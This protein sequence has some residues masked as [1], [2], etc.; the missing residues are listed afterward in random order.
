MLDRL[1][2]PRTG[3]DAEDVR[4]CLA[5]L[6][7]YSVPML[8]QVLAV[9]PRASARR[10]LCDLIVDI[11]RDEVDAVATFV[12]DGRWHL[13]RNTANILGRFGDTR[14]IPHLVSLTG[15]PE[16]RVRREAVEALVRLGT[17]EAEAA[18]AAF[19]DDGD[20]RIRLKAVLSLSDA[21]V[22]HALPT[23]LTLL[24]QADPLGRQAP[25]KEAIITAVAR[26]AVQQAVP[27]LEHLACRRVLAPWN[28]QLR[29]QARDA[30]AHITARRSV[31]QPPPPR[32]GARVGSI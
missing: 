32:L 3:H 22:C 28:R 23:L 12:K 26:V 20:A 24:Q 6:A 27:V 8:M 30:L 31:T 1:W 15:H 10:A 21:G 16:Y 2:A 9:E 4:A 7:S 14:A 19:L 11:A 18:I 29:R 13:V 25:I 5:F 17:D